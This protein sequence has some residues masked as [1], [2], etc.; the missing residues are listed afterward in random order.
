MTD[1]GAGGHGRGSRR[2]KRMLTAEKTDEIWLGL[3][4]GEFN[5][6]E[7]AERYGVDRSTVVRIRRWPR[8]RCWRHWASPSRAGRPGRW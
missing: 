2:R 4:T 8:T 3:V 1:V 6:N 5:Q 7:A